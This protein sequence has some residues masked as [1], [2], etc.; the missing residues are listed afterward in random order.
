M[1]ISKQT[2]A[3]IREENWTDISRKTPVKVVTNFCIQFC[4]IFDAHVTASSED[5]R[6][7]FVSA[8]KKRL[9]DI[10]THVRKVRSWT[11][12][13]LQQTRL[14]LPVNIVLVLL[15]VGRVGKGVTNDNQ[16]PLGARAPGQ[17]PTD[18]PE[19]HL[20]GLGLVPAEGG[21][22]LVDEVHQPGQVVR[23]VQ[24]LGQVG[25]ALVAVVTMGNDGGG[26]G[27]EVGLQSLQHVGQ[28][29]SDLGERAAHGARR[30]EGEDNL[31]R[32]VGQHGGR[33]IWIAG[34]PC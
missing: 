10:R 17:V 12:H 20:V 3:D 2:A 16:N 31:Q 32:A 24:V 27:G 9:G 14:L 1:C 28:T 29:T 7:T 18:Q 6:L 13:F 23:E 4:I 33:H 19:H 15:V 25:L 30:V 8:D 11:H 26:D 5:M 22:D 21:F 34:F